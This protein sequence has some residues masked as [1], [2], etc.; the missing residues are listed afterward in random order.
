MKL[1]IQRVTHASVT[2]DNNVIGKIGKG[3]MVLIGVSDTDTK[4][5]A[6]RCW[7]R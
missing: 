5:I 4:E 1:V 7:I 2:V 3:Y 6:T